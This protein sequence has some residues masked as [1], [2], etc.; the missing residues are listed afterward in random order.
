MK[1]SECPPFIYYMV[2]LMI[3]LIISMRMILRPGLYTQRRMYH[4]MLYHVIA[5]ALFGGL[6]LWLCS[7]GYKRASHD[8]IVLFFG[9]VM[10]F[11]AGMLIHVKQE[12]VVESYGCTTKAPGH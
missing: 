11:V 8:L 6:L 3:Q 9:L 12:K 1:L 7:I 2:Y 5:G 4:I 10:F